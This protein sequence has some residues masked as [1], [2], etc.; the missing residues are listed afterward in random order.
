[1][2]G[3]ANVIQK[4]RSFVSTLAWGASLIVVT[5]IAGGTLLA[6]YGLNVLDRKTSSVFDFAEAVIHG[7]PELADALPPVLADAIR[8]ERRPDYA[9]ELGVDVRLAES[10]RRR[11]CIRP[12]IELRNNGSEVV[13]LLSMRVVVLNARGEVVAELNEWA[14]T[15][16][17]ADHEWR[18]P[19]LP[20]AERHLAVGTLFVGGDVNVDELQAKV[21][22][23]DVRVWN[24]NA[25]AGVALTA[26]GA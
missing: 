10:G 11:D 23:T 9:R 14:A 12:V 19:L 6:A 25:A 7:L 8:D 20:G 13:S 1:M 17:A 3:Q 26:G 22:I 18:G 15:P 5:A 21:E 2:H 24:P 4:H 16:I